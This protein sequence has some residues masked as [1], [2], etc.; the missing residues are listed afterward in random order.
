MNK[1]PIASC[2]NPQEFARW[3]RN[4]ASRNAEKLSEAGKP[5]RAYNYTV[6]EDEINT[7]FKL[8][9]RGFKAGE[10]LAK[11][12]A[13]EIPCYDMK[14]GELRLGWS[15]KEFDKVKNASVQSGE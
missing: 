15:P 5:L 6:S 7:R 9:P 4:R 8:L 3:W 13:C 14:P 12:Q 2:P 1:N 11:L 10:V